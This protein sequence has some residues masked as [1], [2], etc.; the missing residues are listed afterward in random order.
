MFADGTTNGICNTKY[1]SHTTTTQN[2]DTGNIIIIGCN[3]SQF[4]IYYFIFVPS[5]N[6]LV[7]FNSW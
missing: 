1:T 2:V 4:I 5:G 7:F 3:P 6:V